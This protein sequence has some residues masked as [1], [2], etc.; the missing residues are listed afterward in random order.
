MA[1][2]NDAKRLILAEWEKRRDELDLLIS[3]LRRELGMSADSTSPDPIAI[4]QTSTAPVRVEEIV[5]PGDFFGMS[6]VS[7]AKEFLTRLNKRTATLNEIGAA[8]YRGKCTSVA[9]EDKSLKNLSSLLSRSDEFISVA[10]SRWG[11]SE[12]YPNRSKKSRKGN[13]EGPSVQPKAAEVT[14]DKAAK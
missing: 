7:A 5:T 9:F 2:I 14:A 6:Q 3:A 10:K 1:D 13:G 11:L 12:W 8:L 4:T